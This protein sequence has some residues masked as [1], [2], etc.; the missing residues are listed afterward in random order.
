MG[1]ISL[2]LCSCNVRRLTHRGFFTKTNALLLGQWR[3]TAL[4]LVA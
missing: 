4:E 1:S 2:Q 3:R